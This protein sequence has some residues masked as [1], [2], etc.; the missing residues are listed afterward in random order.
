MRYLSVSDIILINNRICEK[1]NQK[2]TILNSELL[3][4]C[5]SSCKATFDGKYL[6]KT[7]SDRILK[8]VYSIVTL[9]PFSDSNKRTAFV[10]LFCLAR[11]N[12]LYVTAPNRDT[13]QNTFI[14]IA[15]GRMDFDEFRNTI[16][17]VTYHYWKKHV[18]QSDPPN[19]AYKKL[20]KD[21]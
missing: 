17:I 8:T 1:Q 19:K 3:S 13:L 16:R 15:S 2:A 11:M 14:D 6:Y 20:M 10:A 5:S 4:Q 7:A 9:H 12:G 18:I 21:L